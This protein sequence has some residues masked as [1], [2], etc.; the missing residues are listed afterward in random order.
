[1]VELPSSTERESANELVD[2]MERDALETVGIE[3]ERLAATSML[4]LSDMLSALVGMVGVIEGA[5]RNHGQSELIVE[6]LCGSTRVA[7]RRFQFLLLRFY[8]TGL[9]NVSRFCGVH[10]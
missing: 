2:G 5:K 7:T 9:W 4:L 3:K 10:F 1:M 8:V 6:P